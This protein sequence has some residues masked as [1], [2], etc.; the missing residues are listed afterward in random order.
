MKK[1]SVELGYGIAIGIVIAV[2]GLGGLGIAV[3]CT[4]G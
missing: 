3:Y 4:L 1:A 2:I